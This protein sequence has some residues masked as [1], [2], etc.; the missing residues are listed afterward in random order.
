MKA[1]LTLKIRNLHA[2]PG[3]TLP[4]KHPIKENVFQEENTI[5]SSASGENWEDIE[6]KY[7][8]GTTKERVKIEPLVSFKTEDNKP[9][10]RLGGSYGKLAGL[11]KEAG[12]TLYEIKAEGFKRSY[13]S[14]VKSIQIKPQWSYLENSEN[15]EISTIPQITAG[16]SQALILLYYEKIPYCETTLSIQIPDSPDGKE[17]FLMLLEQAEGMPFGPKR[18]GEIKVHDLSWIV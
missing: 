4:K 17:K 6:A 3:D 13:K 18:R 12:K 11:F 9:V 1:E 14:F 16:R 5:I 7:K 10:F 8:T 15:V 2:N